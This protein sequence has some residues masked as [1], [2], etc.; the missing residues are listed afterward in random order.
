MT[1]VT[2]FCGFGENPDFS[3][4][5]LTFTDNSL[6]IKNS[7]E[8][9]FLTN[10]EGVYATNGNVLPLTNAQQYQYEIKGITL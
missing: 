7:G 5:K 2:C 4:H 6:T 8:L 10:G 3:G 9:K 1:N